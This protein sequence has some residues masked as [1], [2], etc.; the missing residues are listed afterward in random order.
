MYKRPNDLPSSDEVILKFLELVGDDCDHT[1][2]E[3]C[4]NLASRFQLS[5]QQR[6]MRYE[7]SNELIFNK[8]VRFVKSRLKKCGL[9]EDIDYNDHSF[10]ITKYGKIFL[11]M[12][13]YGIFYRK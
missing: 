9:I 8:L 4:C 6:I 12:G 3:A 1:V 10:R 7:K 11:M 2:S 5:H 13:R